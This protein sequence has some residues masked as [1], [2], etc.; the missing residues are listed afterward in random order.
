MKHKIPQK[1]GHDRQPN[2]KDWTK[3]PQCGEPEGAIVIRKLRHEVDNF[4]RLKIGNFK[5]TDILNMVA[6]I[7]YGMSWAEIIEHVHTGKAIDHEISKQERIPAYYLRHKLGRLHSCY[8]LEE[9]IK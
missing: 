8:G 3:K 7:R 5:R 4:R 9:V 6:N 2:K 1:M